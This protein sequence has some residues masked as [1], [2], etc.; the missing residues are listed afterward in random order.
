[1]P[2]SPESAQSTRR[3]PHGNDRKSRSHSLILNGASLISDLAR[4]FFWG[5]S[6]C[7]FALLFCAKNCSPSLPPARNLRHFSRTIATFSRQRTVAAAK[8]KN[9]LHGRHRRAVLEFANDQ[10]GREN[11]STEGR[12]WAGGQ[13][14]KQKTP[15]LNKQLEGSPTPRDGRRGK[16]REA[17]LRR[18]RNCGGIQRTRRIRLF[19]PL[20]PDQGFFPI[21]RPPES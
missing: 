13:T 17:Y 2:A 20:L 8:N 14:N 15:A 5:R 11:F 16:C 18:K 7:F 9:E 3:T 10:T 1:M 6:V 12:E 21:L 4:L 19:F